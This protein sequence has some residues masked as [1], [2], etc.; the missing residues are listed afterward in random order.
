[1]MMNSLR[2]AAI[3]V[4]VDRWGPAMAEGLLHEVQGWMMFML[5]TGVLVLEAVWL[6]RRGSTHQ[7][8]REVFGLQPMTALP[9]TAKRRQRTLPAPLL[10][11]AGAVLVFTVAV[12]VAPNPAGQAPGRETFANF[13]LSVAGWSGRR[14]P[15]EPVYLDALKLDDY[16]LADY[17]GANGLPV[18]LY[19]AWYDT[20]HAGDSTH[21]PRACLP[22][23]GWRIQDLRQIRLV[24]AKSGAEP[25]RVNRALI[26]YGDQRQLVYY[27]FQQRGRVVTSEYLVKWYLLIDALTRHRTD[28]A[29]VRVIVPISSAMSASDADRELQSFVTAIAPRL[30]P[31]IPS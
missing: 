15:L 2:V 17:V 23:G 13:P 16:L 30:A 27:W 12:V 5:S 29:L 10:G 25:L 22:G 19:V 11:A 1:L 21:S 20:Q 18:N 8:F 28:G 14:E 4:M 6:A 9:T 24:A 31:Y 26:E 3:G 7:S